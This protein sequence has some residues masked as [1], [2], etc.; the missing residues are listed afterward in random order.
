MNR[1]RKKERKK[2]EKSRR[3]VVYTKNK[4]LSSW[5]PP[6][7]RNKGLEVYPSDETKGCRPEVYPS[8]NTRGYRLVVYSRNKTKGYCL[9]VDPSN[10]TKGSRLAVD[11]RN[12]TNCCRLAIYQ[13]INNDNKYE[14]LSAPLLIWAPSACTVCKFIEQ[15]VEQVSTNHDKYKASD[16][17]PFSLYLPISHRDA[18][19]VDDAVL[20]LIFRLRGESICH[21]LEGC[22]GVLTV[23]LLP[24]SH[25]SKL[26][27]SS[28]RCLSDDNENNMRA[29]LR[30]RSAAL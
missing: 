27:V 21:C 15:G 5:S 10:K 3:P 1:W 20:M 4:R 14:Y 22:R 24:A 19:S 6:E 11:P 9:I 2:N 26:M 25:W 28:R 18:H 23:R 16:T 29:Q 17:R 8:S 12:K 7:Q 30:I 13:G